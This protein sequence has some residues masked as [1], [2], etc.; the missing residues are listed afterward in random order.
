MS[1]TITTLIGELR[2]DHRNMAR[3]LDLL[4]K[5]GDEIYQGGTPNLALM[6]DIMRYM[7]VYPDAVHHPKEDRLYAELRAVHPDR[8]TGMRRIAGEHRELEEQSVSLLRRL[9]QAAAGDADS[10]REVVAAASR[11]ADLLRKHMRWEEADLFRRLDKLA[12]EGHDLVDKAVVID[13]RDPLFGS[14]VEESFE[15]LYRCITRDS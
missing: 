14:K 2:S 3:L 15:V 6:C 4:E 7:T 8:A 11:Y 10:F 1:R 5:E 9:E 12:A 13:Q